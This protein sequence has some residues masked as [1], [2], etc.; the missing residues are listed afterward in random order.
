MFG[1]WVWRCGAVGFALI[2]QLL[3]QAEF[4]SFE[5]FEVFEVS[6]F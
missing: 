5:V 4:K 1:N 2:V 3:G 6:T